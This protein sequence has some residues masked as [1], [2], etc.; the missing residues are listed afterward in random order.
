[1][2]RVFLAV[3]E[4]ER[5]K[6]SPMKGGLTLLVGLGEGARFAAHAEA[7]ASAAWRC[8]LEGSAAEDG[9]G[10]APLCRI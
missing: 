5:R 2:C 10:L 9:A 8:V 7:S 4:D 6:V 1:M 3:R